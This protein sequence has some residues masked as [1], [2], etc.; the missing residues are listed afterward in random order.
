MLQKFALSVGMVNIVMSVAKSGSA[1]VSFLSAHPH[2]K[3]CKM[4]NLCNKTRLVEM[5][6]HACSLTSQ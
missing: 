4:T 1:F 2:A 6:L 3:S 5:R